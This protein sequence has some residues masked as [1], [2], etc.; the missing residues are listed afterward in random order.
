MEGADQVLAERGVDAGL[1]ADRAVDLGQQTR[2]DLHEIDAA[3]QGRRGKAGQIADDAAAQGDEHRAALDAAT[4][5]PFGE[6][7]E[8]LEVLGFLAGRQDHARLC[9]PGGGEA[10]AQRLEIMRGDIFVGDDDHLAPPQQR[11]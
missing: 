10:G 4:E 9:D 3:Q 1:A 2:R 5:H 8:M 6:P 7:P 11:A